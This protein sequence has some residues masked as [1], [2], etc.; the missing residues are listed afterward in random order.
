M[1]VEVESSNPNW[2]AACTDARRLWD[3]AV[4]YYLHFEGPLSWQRKVSLCQAFE[5]LPH[6]DDL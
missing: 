3:R 4:G 1:D 2:W 6:Q 5:L